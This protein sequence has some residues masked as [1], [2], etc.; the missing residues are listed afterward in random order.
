MLAISIFLGLLLGKIKIKG[1]TLGITWVLF[2]GIG[3]SA[4]GVACN[5]DMLHIIKEFGLILFVT[6]VG[7]QVGPGFFRSF[8]KGGLAMNIMAL[9]NV[10]LGVGITVII[11]KMAN[12]ELTDM[13]GVYTGAITNTPGLSAAQQAVGDL[14][15]EGASERLAAGYAVAYPLAVV[16]M[17]VSCL[18]LRWFCRIDLKKEPT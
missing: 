12:Q 3:L 8:K 7:L 18:L 4:L 10:A 6:A 17:I 11:A 5:H 14:G 9:V 1:I 16:G 2:V 15:I 13:A